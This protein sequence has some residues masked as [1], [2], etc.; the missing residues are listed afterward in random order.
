MGGASGWAGPA[1]RAE[2]ANPQSVTLDSAGNQL[3]TDPENGL[4]RV[5][6]VR[7]GTFYRRAMTGGHIYTVAGG[8]LHL[9]DKGRPLKRTSLPPRTWR[10][11]ARATW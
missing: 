4:V 1:T 5:V 8:G 6:A 10:W 11:T 2:L 7:T 9:G 3:I